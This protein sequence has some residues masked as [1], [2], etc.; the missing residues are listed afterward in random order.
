MTSPR[1][2]WRKVAES[3]KT[4]EKDSIFFFDTVNGNWGDW[5]EWGECSKTCGEGEHG[6]TRQCNN[7]APAYGGKHCEGPFRQRRPCKEQYCP[8]N[9]FVSLCPIKCLSV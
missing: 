7:P 4:D 2:Q 9:E 5:G 3:L 1:A 8:G 6:R